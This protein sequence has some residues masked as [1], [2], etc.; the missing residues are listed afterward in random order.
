MLPLRLPGGVEVTFTLT[1]NEDGSFTLSYTT[2]EPEEILGD[3]NG[4]GKVTI[5]DATLIQRYL[6]EMTVLTDKQ[7]RLADVNKDGKVNIRDVSQIQRFVAEYI[8]EF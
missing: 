7:L 5:D 8:S 3:V 6:A 2:E 1:K 4:D